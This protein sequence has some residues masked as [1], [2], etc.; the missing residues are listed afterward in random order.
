MLRVSPGAFFLKGDTVENTAERRG[1]TD[2]Y[3]I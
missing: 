3:I 1:N 2:E